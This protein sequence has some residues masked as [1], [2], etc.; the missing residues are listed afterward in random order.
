MEIKLHSNAV[1]TPKIRDYIRSNSHMSNALLG[2]E[3]GISAPTVAKWK[4]RDNSKDISSRPHKLC[5]DLTP[6][7]ELIIVELRRVLLIGLDDLLC[8]IKDYIKSD[9]SR[10]ALYRCLKRHDVSN[11]EDITPKV[12]YP[13]EAPKKFKEY[14]VGYIHIDVKYLPKM[15]D[16]KKRSY[17]YVAIDRVSRW[18]HTKVYENKTA[19]NAESFIEEVME[20]YPA[21]IHT[22]LTDNGKEF[23]DRFNQKSKNPSGKHKVDKICQNNDIKHKLTRPYT[24]KTNGMVERFNGRISEILGKYPFNSISEMENKIEEF[25]SYY[26]CIKK[27][28][29]LKYKTPMQMLGESQ[30]NLSE[31]DT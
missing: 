5:T 29:V 8:V 27:H 18:V 13:K 28:A 22:I 7:E 11:L 3:L 9:I 24:P 21:K 6:Q 20:H 25:V 30:N 15:P 10:S 31:S 23:T 4:S 2:R 1:T 19:N 14:E 12:E 17:L 16:Q 26:N